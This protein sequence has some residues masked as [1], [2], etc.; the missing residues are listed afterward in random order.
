MPSNGAWVN[1]S[2][3]KLSTAAKSAV[4]ELGAKFVTGGGAIR[5]LYQG[6]TWFLNNQQSIG[7]LVEQF[8]GTL[9]LVTQD[10]T[11]NLFRNALT[12]VLKNAVPVIL[13]FAV[14]QLGLA[15]LP[16][17]VRSAVQFVPNKVY[18]VLRAAV[19]KVTLPGQLYK[20]ALTSVL[21]IGSDYQ[22]WEARDDNGQAHVKVAKRNG[23]NQ[24]VL[25]AELKETSFTTTPSREHIRD[26]ITAAK[27]YAKELDK[28]KKTPTSNGDVVLKNLQAEVTR[29]Q[30]LVK[31]DIENDACAALGVGCFAAGTRMCTPDGF[32]NIEEIQPNELVYARSEFDPN[33]PIEAKIVEEVFER[34]SEI[35]HLHVAGQVIRTTGEHPFYA[36]LAATRRLRSEALEGQWTKVDD[37]QAGDAILTEAGEWKQVEEVYHTGE[38]E[39]VYNLRVADHHTYFVGEANWGWCAWAHNAYTVEFKNA[40]VAA[41]TAQGTLGGGANRTWTQELF[42]L[43]QTNTHQSWYLFVQMLTPKSLSATTM[44]D[45]WWIARNQNPALFAQTQAKAVSILQPVAQ[46]IATLLAP[47][48]ITAP[49][50]GIR[51]S[52]ATGYSWDD[53]SG[54]LGKPWDGS[55]FDVDAYVKNDQLANI[56][57]G[58][59]VSLRNLDQAE[60]FK[61]GQAGNSAANTVISLIVHAQM[62]LKVAF[63]SRLRAGNFTFKVFA[64]SSGVSGLNL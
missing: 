44:R 49:V 19:S 13:R 37:L 14:D 46:Q 48:G 45:L 58:T 20:G 39:T 36:R 57:P 42:D 5:A 43:A 8:L 38:W 15:K 6:F 9:T 33:G 52:L 3:A 53:S 26:L 12:P 54:T 7:T 60:G 63:G 64:S 16:D 51:G 4:V 61:P 30:G 34:F 29:L 55:N 1:E 28:Q 31:A 56:I 17:E 25:F 40:L 35:L 27:N 62:S 22:L 32:R 2:R 24:F 41:L 50:F 59:F 18:G 11:G 23:Q 21:T 47:F 10:S